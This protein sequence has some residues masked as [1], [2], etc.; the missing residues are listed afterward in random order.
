VLILVGTL[1]YLRGEEA[2]F[3][4][5]SNKGSNYLFSLEISFSVGIELLYEIFTDMDKL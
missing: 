5:L 2:G 1:T 3:C 4:F